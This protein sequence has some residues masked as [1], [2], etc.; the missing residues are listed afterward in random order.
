MRLAGG[1]VLLLYL[2]ATTS[3]G[4]APPEKHV[5]WTV[6]PADPFSE[7][8][9][10]DK[11]SDFKL[12]V[13]RGEILRLNLNGTP[14]SGWHT[15]PIHKAAAANNPGQMS[16]VGVSSKYFALIRPP[17]ESEPE[18][19][20]EK[21]IGKQYQYSDPFTFTVDVVVR[22]DAPVGQSLQLPIEVTQLVCRETCITEKTAL[23]VPV[24]VTDAPPLP[25]TPEVAKLLKDLD[26]ADKRST[27][28]K[29][30]TT[31]AI[32]ATVNL[33]EWEIEEG[34]DTVGGTSKGEGLRATIIKAIIAGF[35]S[36]VT[37][38]VFP[39]IPVTVSIFL[40]RSEVKA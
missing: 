11:P 21:G 3:A 27:E 19:V 8:N 18:L 10:R 2:F 20:D 25:L 33:E 36:L 39:M 40:K 16:T 35:I 26:E 23:N 38:C 37:P 12:T 5:K 17:T 15:Y 29:K 31:P 4:A 6:E 34:D 1:G 22:P 14:D 13:R 9:R 32:T 28:A 24:L 7:L 30:D